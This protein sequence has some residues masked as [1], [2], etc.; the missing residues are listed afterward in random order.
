MVV[1][2]W[3]LR[4]P[5]PLP[6]RESCTRRECKIL[7]EVFTAR[8]GITAAPVVVVLVLL[9]VVLVIVGGS[10]DAWCELCPQQ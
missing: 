9:V 3:S 7:G 10:G 6:S 8:E 2:R 5:Q 4:P 1:M